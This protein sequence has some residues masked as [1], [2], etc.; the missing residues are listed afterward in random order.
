M[1]LVSNN[2]LG[3]LDSYFLSRLAVSNDEPLSPRVSTRMVLGAI[4]QLHV[5]T[6]IIIEETA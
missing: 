1:S 5:G 2:S 3:V 4:W 6:D